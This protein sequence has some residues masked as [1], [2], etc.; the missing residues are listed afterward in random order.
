[1]LKS[2]LVGRTEVEKSRIRRDVE[3]H[4]AQSVKTLVHGLGDYSST[5][6]PNA[7]LNR[8]LRKRRAYLKPPLQLRLPGDDEPSPCAV[9]SLAFICS[10]FWPFLRAPD[11]F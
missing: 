1:M 4:L 10:S 3:G 6:Q 5:A 11:F 8:R 9:S 7:R 2:L